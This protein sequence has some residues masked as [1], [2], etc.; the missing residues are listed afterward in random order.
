MLYLS[1]AIV[2]VAII[3]ARYGLTITIH[4][5]HELIEDK[6]LPITEPID[7]LTEEERNK[8]PKEPTYDDLMRNLNE[9]IYELGGQDNE[10]A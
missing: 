2:I 9:I 5:T 1:I 4:R 7:T 10:T 8:I 3:S 6:P